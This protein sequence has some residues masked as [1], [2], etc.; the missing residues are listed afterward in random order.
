MLETSFGVHFI[1]GVSPQQTFYKWRIMCDKTRQGE[2]VW[3]TCWEDLGT[4]TRSSAL[5]KTMSGNLQ[6]LHTHKFTGLHYV[7]TSLF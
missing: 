3:E 4:H 7:C 2:G 1:T 5:K 6:L